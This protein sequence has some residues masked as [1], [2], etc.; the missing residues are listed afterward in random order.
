M[1]VRTESRDSLGKL[2]LN[3]RKTWHY[4]LA[5]VTPHSKQNQRLSSRDPARTVEDGL[6]WMIWPSADRKFGWFVEPTYSYSFSRGH[7]QSIG[8]TT[9]LI[10]AIP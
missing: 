7:E 9:G 3:Q 1:L 10:I 6:E 4:T 8:V 5:K 2:N